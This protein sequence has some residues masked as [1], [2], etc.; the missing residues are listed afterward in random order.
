M[1]H[2]HPFTSVLLATYLLVGAIL[3]ALRW[4]GIS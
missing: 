4:F 2:R 1:I 3:Q